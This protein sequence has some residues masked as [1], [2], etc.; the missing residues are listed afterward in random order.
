VG[1][2]CKWRTIKKIT[3]FAIWVINVGA[4]ASRKISVIDLTHIKFFVY[5]EKYMAFYKKV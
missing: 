5:G 2:S 4:I 3:L 1:L